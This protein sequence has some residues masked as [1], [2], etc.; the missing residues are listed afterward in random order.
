MGDDSNTSESNR[1][2]IVRLEREIN[3]LRLSPS[4]R[5]GEHITKAMRF[6]WRAPFLIVTLPILMLTIGFEMLGRRKVKFSKEVSRYN[7]VNTRKNTVVMFPTNGIGFGHFTRM[8]A[9][10]NRMKKLDP[11]L[12]IIFF[13][14]MPTLHI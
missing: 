9:T 10:A 12:E 13:T 8:L 4:L 1:K 7:L 6:P 11:D 5:L 2:R 14:T 3:R